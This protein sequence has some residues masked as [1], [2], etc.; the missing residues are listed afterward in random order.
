MSLPEELQYELD[1]S[2]KEKC[3]QKV[4]E[5]MVKIIE[6][7]D[8]PYLLN[9]AHSGTLMALLHPETEESSPPKTISHLK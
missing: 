7:S 2:E 4:Y 3:T 6:A 5:K 1:L 8:Y 9:Q